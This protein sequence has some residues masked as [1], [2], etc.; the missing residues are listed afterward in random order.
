MEN[1]QELVLFENENTRLDFKREE[2]R[3]ENYSSFLKD[4]ISM[5]NA[6][7]KEDKYI[8]IGLKPKT[9]ENRGFVGVGENITDAA[10]FQQ[11]TYENIEPE[12]KIDYFPFNFK[13]YIF[14]IFKI[15]ACDNP[16]Y[17]MKKD[18]GN[19]KNKLYRGEGFIRKGTHQTRLVRTDFDIFTQKKMDLRFFNEKVEFNLITESLKNELSSINL[20]KIERPSQK[21]KK[22]IEEILKE[23]KLKAQEYDR[24]GLNGIDFVNIKNSMAIM[25]AAATGGGIPYENRDIPT[26]EQDL[27]DVEETYLEDD[28]YTL[29][30]KNSN[31]CNI[32]INNNGSK[33]IEDATIIITIPKIENIFVSHKIHKKPTSKTFSDVVDT[34]FINYPKVGGNENSYI[35]EHQIG[36]IKHQLP[37]DA[38][39]VPLRVVILDGI[40]EKYINISCELFAKNI[41]T[42]IKK[43][44]KIKIIQS[45]ADSES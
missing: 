39:N 24:L 42:S 3:K 15:Y 14:G 18:Y 20:K 29:F 6:S 22:K 27:K 4:V 11:L 1:L 36:N 44:L 45:T 8:I 7:T 28:Y 21:I 23:K 9:I 32:Q 25:Q 37:E 41:K 19:G 43:E 33:Y 34:S 26:L 16:P 31:K 40:Q 30:E 2:Y 17:L 12:L 35:I 13:E 38:F 5:A 10:T